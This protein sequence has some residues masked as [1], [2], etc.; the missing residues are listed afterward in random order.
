[1]I[2]IIFIF[3]FVLFSINILPA[4]M[5]VSGILDSSVSVN[6]DPES[7]T[8]LSGLEE[9]ANIRF[10]SRLR[11]RAVV[12]GAVN[13]IAASGNYAVLVQETLSLTGADESSGLNVSS[14][15]SGENFI[16][17]IELERL[18]FRLRGEHL[19]FDS[20]LFRLP[21]G[22]GQVWSPSD[23]LNPKNPLKPDARPRAVLGSALT[24]YPIEELK[25]LGFYTA[26][27]D[28][29]SSDG[30]GSLTGFSMDRHW[31]RV[32]LQTLYS[33]ETP[34]AGSSKG[35]HRV[36][37]SVKLDIKISFTADALYTYNHEAET[38]IS[39]L[40]VSAGFDYSFFDGKLITLAEYL[41]NGEN[42]SLAYSTNNIFGFLNRHYIYTGL[43]WRFND[44]TN[45]SAALITSF[46][47]ITYTPLIIL[48][49]DIFQGA[50]LTVSVQTPFDTNTF[51]GVNCTAKVRLRF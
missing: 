4:Q 6:V 10:Q 2:K 45:L 18:Y 1:M 16:T 7:N 5:S 22:Y 41:Y 35:I 36:G 29:F 13:L 46:E 48:N 37:L 50:V 23:F 47:E 34:N 28:P 17:A 27:R 11:D 15:V 49:H 3:L 44:F 39:G 40:S 19:D 20:G 30:K 38:E 8:V 14:Y 25:L 24:L 31:E 12:Y 51:Y 43:T 32:S 42:S 26:P 21:F 33:F 9:F